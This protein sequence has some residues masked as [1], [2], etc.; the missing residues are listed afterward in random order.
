MLTYYRP[1]F[2]AGEAGI[3]VL[4]PEALAPESD[5][6]EEDTRPPSPCSVR[7][8][9]DNVL[10]N[11]KSSMAVKICRDR[12]AKLKLQFDDSL[13]RTFEYPS[14]TSLCED[15]SS[16]T[17]NA[18]ANSPAPT[19]I[20][21]NTNNN[22]DSPQQIAQPAHL[23]PLVA[24]THIVSASLSRYTPSKT[25]ADAF[26]LGLTRRAD[27]CTDAERPEVEDGEA[28]EACE[29]R[30]ARCEAEAQ[31]DAELELGDA[32][33]CAAESARSWSEARTHATDLLF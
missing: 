15:S 18:S 2:Q 6:E 32:R 31:A 4:R 21:A 30:E 14:E 13:T 24:N 19:D 29:A 23:A 33:P 22:G 1:P 27:H 11:G 25:R 10:I 5:S 12:A 28:R 17:A 16:P 3:V 26:Q 20:N 7:F 8:V 9:N